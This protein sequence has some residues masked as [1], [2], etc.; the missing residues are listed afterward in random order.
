MLIDTRKMSKLER[1]AF[2][3]ELDYAESIFRNEV[4]N[5]YQRYVKKG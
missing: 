4:N 2:Y 1:E 3:A 5:I